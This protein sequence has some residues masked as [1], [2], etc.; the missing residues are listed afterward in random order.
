MEQIAEP[1]NDYLSILSQA[2][3]RAVSKHFRNTIVVKNYSWY[4]KYKKIKNCIGRE[5]LIQFVFELDQDFIETDTYYDTYYPIEN[6]EY[7][8][9]LRYFILNSDWYFCIIDFAETI[10]ELGD[11][12]YNLIEEVCDHVEYYTDYR[13]LQSA[14]IQLCFE[15]YKI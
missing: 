15:E 10:A 5:I 9:K 4:Q 1:V 12:E 3:L 8:E 14:L 11:I 13:P 6:H 2:R 7:G